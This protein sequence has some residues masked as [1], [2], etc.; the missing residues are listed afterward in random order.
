[1]NRE[2]VITHLQIIRTWAAFARK[3][4]LQFFTAKHL[5]DVVAWTDDAIEL[6]KEQEK[7]RF[8][9]DK[10]GHITPLTAQEPETAEIEIEGGGSSWWYVCSECHGTIDMCDQFCRHCGKRIKRRKKEPD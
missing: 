4:D 3:R 7:L 6:L 1:M 2:S 9:I 5:D 8:L 10:N